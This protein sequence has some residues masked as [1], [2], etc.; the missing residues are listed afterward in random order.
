MA[1]T[2]TEDLPNGPETPASGPVFVGAQIYRGSSYGSAH[3]LAIP[4]VPTVNDLCRKLGWLTHDN[5]RSSPRAK[6]AALT[7]F[8]TPTYIAALVQA[9]SEQSVSALVRERH[10][11]GTLANPVYPEMFRRPATSVGGVMLG[12]AIIANG[13]TAYVPGGGTHHGMPDRANGFCYLNDPVMGILS[14]KQ[15]GLRRVVYV[16]IDAHHCDGVEA[17][18]SGQEGV[19][20][21]SIHEE[22]RWPF[23]G[24]LTD[25]AGGTAFNLPVPRDLNDTE[26]RLALEQF[27]LPAVAEF[28][29]DAIVL[30][31][32]CDAVLEDPLSRLALSNN[33]HWE[34]VSALNELSDRFL[35][36]GGGGYNPWSVARCWAG[37][38]ATLNGLEIPDR[39]PDDSQSILAALRWK[40]KS[41]HAPPDHWITTLRD[42]PRQG[43]VRDE[44]RSRVQALRRR[45]FSDRRSTG[46]GGDWSSGERSVL[47]GPR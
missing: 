10:G 30:Q 8:H 47:M 43:P 36:L 4:R 38:W 17:A 31:C 44:I 24:A 5:Y 33:C 37:V 27:V 34:A 7:A 18:F 46:G 41:G 22:N 6:P 15:Q 25:T 21:I 20:L 23:T 11:L 9:E 19:R 29:P 16:D 13:G 14:L 28:H 1:R 39:L 42:S 12:A 3:P 32:G 40:R 45:L 2:G 26:F 35:V